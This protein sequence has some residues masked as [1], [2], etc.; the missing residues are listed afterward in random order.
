MFPG[1]NGIV[2]MEHDYF[3]DGMEKTERG[4]LKSQIRER[5]LPS[6]DLPLLLVTKMRGWSDW[7]IK[8]G[9]QAEVAGERML[10]GKYVRN[11]IREI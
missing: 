4:C 11:E 1:I 7:F 5:P 10:I 3:L 2:D 6:V 8:A 9:G